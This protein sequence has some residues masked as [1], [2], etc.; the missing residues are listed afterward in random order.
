MHRLLLFAVVFS[1]GLFFLTGCGSVSKTASF[2]GDRQIS[3]GELAS[4]DLTEREKWNLARQV[5]DQA[6]HE[7]KRGDDE[8]AAYY[9]SVTLEL[10]GSLDLASIEL[11]TQRVLSFQRK[12]LKSYD[13]FLK[14][15]E[16]LPLTAGPAAVMEAG[17]LADTADETEVLPVN[18]ESAAVPHVS[19]KPGTQKLPSVPTTLN[20]KVQTHI[21]FFKGKGRQVMLRWMERSATVFPRMRPILIEEGIPEELM[22]LAMIESGLNLNAYSYAHAAGVWQFIPST[23]RLYGLNVDGVYDERR[24]L[25]LATRAACRHLRDLYTSFGDWYLALAAYNTGEGRVRRH[26]KRYKTDNYWKLRYLPRQTRN[27]VPTFLAA[28][29]ICENPEEYGFPPR[30]REIPFECERVLVSDSY[31]FKHIAE[32]AGVDAA[33]VKALNPEFV[34][35]VVPGDNTPMMIRLPSAPDKA[36]DVRLAAM[37]I[38]EVQP[39]TVHRVRRGETLS[40]IAKRYGTTVRAIRSL[41]EN[42]HIKPTRLQIG[43]RVI[44]PVPSTSYAERRG[45]G[46]KKIEK[47]ETAAPQTTASGGH[48]I[49]YTVSR[50]ETLGR[51]GR[52]LGVSVS[53]ICREN[54]IRN[55][56]R[57]Y[58]GQRLKIT[59]AGKPSYASELSGEKRIYTVQPGDTVWDI[60][61]KYG[62]DTSQILAWNQLN[63]RSKIYP[64]QKLIVG[65]K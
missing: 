28:R 44:V 31:S 55:P 60:A 32:A 1:A 59:V 42:R 16:S 43:Q 15:V 21:K 63:R 52:Q 3:P 57:V 64:G 4:E 56:N 27:Y 41:P 7:E 24:H 49:T 53:Q 20:S 46:S 10:L 38:T 58:P 25:E 36:F 11:P 12:V 54:N 19:V 29:A 48:Q 37:P 18:G 65:V 47:D 34:Q 13:S 6:I 62:Q 40:H 39:T 17:G 8:E 22:Y 14:S 26:M 50:G 45:S 23:A 51:I 33:D 35:D 61:N 2:S 9:Y 5:Y 30:P